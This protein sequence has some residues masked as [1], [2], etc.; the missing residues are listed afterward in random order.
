MKKEKKKQEK[1]PKKTEE[2][3]NKDAIELREIFKAVREYR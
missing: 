2:Q 3:L 1:K